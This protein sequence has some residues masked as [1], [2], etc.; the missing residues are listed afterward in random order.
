MP[1]GFFTIVLRTEVING[2]Y[3]FATQTNG[4]DCCKSPIDMFS[5]LHIDND[6][7]AVDEAI[8]DF[9]QLNQPA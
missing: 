5:D 7:A 4:Q 6:L 1:E 8:C 9:Y 3:K 2:N